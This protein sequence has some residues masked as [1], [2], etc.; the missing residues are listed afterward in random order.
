MSSDQAVDRL[1][2]GR[3]VAGIARPEGVVTTLHE[4]KTFDGAKVLGALHRLDGAR[5]VV[6]LMHPRQQ[7][8]HHPMVDYFL[9]MGLAVWTQDS[10]SPNNDVNLIHE[11][12]ILD[13]AAGQ[14]FL[15]DAG[16]ESLLT[17]GHSGGGALM[18]YYIEQAA[19]E[20]EFRIDV[21][22]AGRPISL[23][24]AHM[25]IPDAALFLAPHPGQGL[26]LLSCIDPSVGDESDPLSVVSDLDMYDPANGFAPP[27]TSSSYS[28]AFL[29][30]YR[31]AQLR[32]VERIDAVAKERAGEAAE[33]RVRFARTEDSR[34]RRA[35]LAPRVITTYRTDADPR[36]VDLSIDPSDRPYGSLFGRRPDLTNYGL[37]GFGRFATPEAWLSTWSGLSSNAAFERCAAGIHIP[38]M[39]VE[40]SG[41]QAA[42][43]H[44]ADRMF[45]AIPAADKTRKVVRGQH[46]GQPISPDEPTG[47]ES[48]SAVFEPW[49]ASRFELVRPLRTL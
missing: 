43:S 47:Y 32:R 46:F 18:A 20:P 25:P 8:T 1:G 42:H 34:D 6:S 27:G 40:F 11:Q 21:T 16:F 33:A 30:D 17:F 19:I 35:A 29:S 7:L 13:L 9:R 10:R 26:V 2:A 4:L 45:G 22:P 39:Y 12:A 31:K 41:D 36:Y 38:T 3:D 37:V 23:A 48:A 44:D 14:V 28:P 5:A 24:G 49:I 15:R